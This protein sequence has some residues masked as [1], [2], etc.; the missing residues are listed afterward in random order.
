MNRQTLP[1]THQRSNMGHQIT[2]EIVDEI[3]D[4]LRGRTH[5]ML[6]SGMEISMPSGDRPR[7]RSGVG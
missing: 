7:E 3:A 4:I 6:E 2:R 1:T 5:S